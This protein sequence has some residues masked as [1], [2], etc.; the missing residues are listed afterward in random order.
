MVLNRGLNVWRVQEARGARDARCKVHVSWAVAEDAAGS[1]AM[2]GVGQGRSVGGG[3]PQQTR[4]PGQT[5][6]ADSVALAGDAG[7]CHPCSGR[8]RVPECPRWWGNGVL[9]GCGESGPVASPSHLS[10]SPR[11]T[12]LRLC[13]PS[14]WCRTAA[15]TV[16]PELCPQLLARCAG[17]AGVLSGHAPSPPPPGI[18]ICAPV[19]AE[20]LCL[21]LHVWRGSFSR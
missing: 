6:A 9:G 18:S 17:P 20:P 19:T 8:T 7:A 4:D 10:Q 21:R 5:Q 16:P 15:S 12:G 2:K 11:G 1:S 3:G 13:T 14:P